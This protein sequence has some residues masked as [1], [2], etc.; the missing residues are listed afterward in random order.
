MQYLQ[1]ILG[2][3][4]DPYGATTGVSKKNFKNQ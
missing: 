2:T 3:K 1:H 4:K